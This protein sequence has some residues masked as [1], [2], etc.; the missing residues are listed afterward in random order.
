MDRRS[1]MRKVLGLAITACTPIVPLSNC[2]NPTI[3]FPP[4]GLKNPLFGKNGTIGNW[5]GLILY[6]GGAPRCF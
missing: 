2:L 4:R 3:L 1:F 5:D 6:E